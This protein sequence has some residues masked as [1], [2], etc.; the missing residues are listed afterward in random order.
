MAMRISKTKT[1]RVL[2]VILWGATIVI[3]LLVLISLVL[4]VG[5]ALKYG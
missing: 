1:A 3:G 4:C 2:L 5:E